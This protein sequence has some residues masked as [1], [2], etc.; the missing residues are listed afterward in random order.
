[1]AEDFD[2]GGPLPEEST[3]RPFIVAAA[4]IGGLLVLSMVC[5]ALYALVLA[6]RQRAAR[7]TEA[8][9]IVVQ[10]TQV[11]L[12]ITQTAEAE[13]AP[14]TGTA[15]RTPTPTST[16]T[17]TQV[18][19]L[20]TETPFTTLP[21]LA[22]LTATAAAEATIAALAGGGGSPT[23]TALPS[24]GFA[25]DIGLPNLVLLAAVLL[26]VII[27]ARQVRSRALS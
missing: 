9:N 13:F 3:N 8:A 17:P 6:P 25:E 16:V 12:S 14:P 22:P 23:A 2:V 7:A 20:P 15:T 21:T 10:N 5:L 27:V 1:M 4:L 26:A 11:A 18:V 19:V 24:T